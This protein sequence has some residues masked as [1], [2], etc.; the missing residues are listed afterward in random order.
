MIYCSKDVNIRKLDD[1]NLV[2]CD[3]DY[4]PSKKTLLLCV[5]MDDI[6]YQDGTKSTPHRWIREFNINDLSDNSYSPCFVIENG[7]FEVWCDEE[8]RYL[9]IEELHEK[10]YVSYKG[11]YFIIAATVYASLNGWKEISGEFEYEVRD[12]NTDKVGYIKIRTID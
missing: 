11:K 4:K 2:I 6:Y 10:R 12:V 1:K 5:V 8:G 7:D 9:S 3:S